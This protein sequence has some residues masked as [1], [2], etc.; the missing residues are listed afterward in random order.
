MN[1]NIIDALKSE[2][3]AFQLKSGG[4]TLRSTEQLLANAAQSTESLERAAH[5]STFEVLQFLA[6]NV[7]S[8]Q[9]SIETGGGWST[10]VLAAAAGAH[11]CVNPDITA[12]KLITEFLRKHDCNPKN[13][14]FLELPSDRALPSLPESVKVDLC[15][16]DGNHSYPIPIIDWHYMDLHLNTNGLMLIDDVQI[17][18]VKV[19]C[20]FLDTEPSYKRHAILGT[21]WIYRKVSKDR[22]WGWGDQSFNRPHPLEQAKSSLKRLMGRA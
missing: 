7:T 1:N 19:L 13:L 2:R 9:T 6:D 22:V 21:T 5:S 20:D 12:N 10:C 4:T 18:A 8:S 14:Q 17:R 3:P 15:Y 16:I 11:Y